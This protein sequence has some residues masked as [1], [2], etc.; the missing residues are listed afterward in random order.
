MNFLAGIA[1]HIIKWIISSAIAAVV[2]AIAVWKRRKDAAEAAKKK[3]D[4][5]QAVVDAAKTKEEALRAA[6]A[7]ARLNGPTDL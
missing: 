4:E 2:R 7:N 5:T 6:E 3:I 1:T